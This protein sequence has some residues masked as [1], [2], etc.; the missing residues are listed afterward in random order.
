M[1]QG[2][3][4]E[5]MRWAMLGLFGGIVFALIVISFRIQIYRVTGMDVNEEVRRLLVSDSERVYS[6]YDKYTLNREISYLIVNHAVLN[7]IPVH[8]FFAVAYTESGFSPEAVGGPNEDGTYDYSIF[9][10]NS[11]S[12]RKYDKAYLCIPE[13]NIRLA[14]EHLRRNYDKYKNWPESI[15]EYNTGTTKLLKARGIKYLVS[16]LEFTEILDKEFRRCF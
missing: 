7:R 12:Y 13:N 14:A 4:S 1:M 10:L 16:V 5:V 6:F 3:W 9:Q 2:F 11:K 15:I 8:V